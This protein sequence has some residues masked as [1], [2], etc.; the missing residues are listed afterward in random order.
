MQKHLQCKFLI[1][2]VYSCEIKVKSDYF[3]GG[4][5]GNRTRV[6][7]CLIAENFLHA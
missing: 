4:N 5:D 3:F 1:I 7:K 2:L 6:Q